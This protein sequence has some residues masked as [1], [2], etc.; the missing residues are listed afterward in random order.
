MIV[1]RDDYGSYHVRGT[2]DDGQE[3]WNIQVWLKGSDQDGPADHCF[4]VINGE[5]TKY[6]VESAEKEAVLALIAQWEDRLP[7]MV[8]APIQDPR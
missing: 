3:G 5:V 6:E 8:A 1:E 4:M 2:A 7:L